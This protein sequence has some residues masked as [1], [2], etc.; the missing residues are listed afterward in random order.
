VPRSAYFIISQTRKAIP[1]KA[2][3]EICGKEKRKKKKPSHD[4]LSVIS[5]A[6][7]SGEETV[8]KTRPT[9]KKKV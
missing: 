1:N 4:R 2:I 6:F 5:G 9:E 7:L 3:R 8:E